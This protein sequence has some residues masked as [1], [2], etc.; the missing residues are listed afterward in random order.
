MKPGLSGLVRLKNEEAWCRLALESFVGWCD[1]LVIVLN[2]PTDRTPEIVADFAA[3]HPT[4]RVFDYPHAIWPLGPGH[5]RIPDTDPRASAA[6]Y[7]FTQGQAAYSHAV[8]LDG[9][10]V[11]MDWAGAEIRR[12][13]AAGHHRIKF[14]GTDIVGDDL[15][16][17]GCHPRCPTNGVYQLGRGVRYVQGATT[18]NLRGVPMPTHTIARPAFL[19][20]KWA[21]KS[22][23]A[24]TMQWPANW[25]A[26]EHFRQVASRREPVAPYA[27]EY[28]ASVAALLR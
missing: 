2:A 17:I 14:E 23:A 28:P 1:E 10:M 25:Q 24:A 27:G 4:A 8:K 12:L 26:I 7:N 6:F 9:D 11:M 21:R 22:F 20:F 16:H 19:H 3:R 13:M 18:Q 5:D 15:R